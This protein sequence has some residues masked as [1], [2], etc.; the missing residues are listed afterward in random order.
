MMNETLKTIYE[1]R[2]IRAYKPE[3]IT[4]EELDTVLKAGEYAPSANNQ[5]S[6]KFVAVQDPAVLK[7]LAELGMKVK[8]LDSSPFYGAPTVVLV[9]AKKGCSEPF[10]DG[11][12][13]LGTMFLAA[14]SIGLGS[15]WINCVKKIFDTAEGKALQ[16]RLGVSDEYLSVGSCILGYSAEE[17]KA[18]APRKDDYV[19]YIR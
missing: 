2:S 11:C 1:R 8:N 13:A 15:C 9:F 16:A 12:L 14:K 19:T 10:A 7:E 3:Q 6:A 18:A 5:Q 4:G 17:E